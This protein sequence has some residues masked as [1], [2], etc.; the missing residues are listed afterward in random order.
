[1][2]PP[3]PSPSRPHL[4]RNEGGFAIIVALVL[5]GMLLL[6]LA[7]LGIFTQVQLRTSE[8]VQ[9]QTYARQNALFG[10]KTALNQLQRYAGPD[11]R[12]TAT[13]D[14]TGGQDGTRY[15]TGVWGNR[16][17]PDADERDPLLLNWLVSGNEGLTLDAR[18]SGEDFGMIVSA[19]TPGH[20]PSAVLSPVLSA[21]ASALQE[22]QLGSS[23]ARLLVGPGTMGTTNNAVAGYVAAPL[24]PLH[25]GDGQTQTGAYAYWVGD[26]GTKAR[27]NLVNPYP[28]DEAATSDRT[29]QLAWSFGTAQSVA[30]D[31]IDG[32]TALPSASQPENT[33]LGEL[34]SPAQLP[35]VASGVDSTQLRERFHDL[36]IG[37]SGVLTDTRRGGLK[38]DLS[39]ILENGG[40]STE[41]ENGRFL[42]ADGDGDYGPSASAFYTNPP[43]WGL[44]RDF[45]RFGQSA[46]GTLQPQT[47]TSTRQGINPVLMLAS[48]SY[49]LAILPD[50]ADSTRQII[51]VYASP[52][53]FLWNPYDRPL[54]AGTYEIGFQPPRQQSGLEEGGTVTITLE[55]TNPADGSVTSNDYTFNLSSGQFENPLT[56]DRHFFRFNLV[57]DRPWQPG[58]TISFM[59]PQGVQDYD[60]TGTSLLMLERRKN[61]QIYDHTRNARARIAS[62]S[63]PA[64]ETGTFKVPLQNMGEANLYLGTPGAG[65]A[66]PGS[67]LNPGSTNT[68]GFYQWIGRVG[69]TT[70]VGAS[71]NNHTAIYEEPT[72]TLP[73]LPDSSLGP[74]ALVEMDVFH[75]LGAG[76]VFASP[77]PTRWIAAANPRAYM[78]NR[79]GMEEVAGGGLTINP[80]YFGL[81]SNFSDISYGSG[82]SFVVPV[83]ANSQVEGEVPLGND[84]NN[85]SFDRSSPYA[86][87]YVRPTLFQLPSEEHPLFSIAD[88]RHALTSAHVTSP[89]YAIGNSLADFRVG[90]GETSVAVDSGYA[91]PVGGPGFGPLAQTLYDQSYRLNDALWD[92]YF[93]ST[94]PGSGALPQQLPNSRLTWLKQDGQIPARTDIADNAGKLASTRLMLEGAFNVNSTSIQAWRAVL[95][96]LNGLRYDP[97]QPDDADAESLSNPFSRLWQT[98]AASTRQSM[99]GNT[100]AN[101]TEH[102]S[103]YRELTEAELD[104]LAERLVDEVRARGPFLS[105]SDFINRAP[106]SDDDKQRLRGA[107]QAAIDNDQ[108]NA[109]RDDASRIN[110]M[111]ESGGRNLNI[112]K[113]NYG[114]GDGFSGDYDVKAYLGWD[115]TNRNTSNNPFTR[116]NYFV[117][118]DVTQADVLAAIGATLTPRSDTFVVRA[119]GESVSP[120]DGTV[121]G[122]A[123]CEA[124]VQRLPE[125]MEAA[126]D[127][128][129]IAPAALTSSLNRQL[130]RRF[131][132]RSFRWLGAD[133]I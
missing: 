116:S 51:E 81:A 15:W 92:R 34:L 42:F 82:T 4:R 66:A 21:S 61:R 60:F 71:A 1:M 57:M 84:Y 5:M 11:Q 103:G 114:Y 132:V 78:L 73:L 68:A 113:D 24:V 124:L 72:F 133:D 18:Q 48:M 16:N 10:L 36:S 95:G 110:Y 83:M 75:S 29:E 12:I 38:R 33:I 50:S 37:S 56:N 9:E 85:T 109:N 105:L 23:P 70:P 101:A 87:R 88:L 117:P 127:S 98:K 93:F 62:L 111:I 126:A 129:D 97:M 2:P 19:G 120:L 106:G 59:L 64:E 6:L 100:V 30:A 46:R 96:S 40:G 67:A 53:V 90:L 112:Y 7:S 35:L 58:E 26:E 52:R 49:S 17:A 63:V 104:G 39:R 131:V 79:T 14:I 122:R 27:L 99:D 118:G 121:E 54:A 125:Y 55:T 115:S 119:Y 45:A 107:I 28:N 89:G 102:Y 130:G 74:T 8:L 128:P 32:L 20:L 69:V 13:A 94:I 3:A 41:E 65:T 108:G 76:G 91:D 86:G 22:F 80:Q 25:D 31:K 77:L 47:P 44:L 43:T 123:W